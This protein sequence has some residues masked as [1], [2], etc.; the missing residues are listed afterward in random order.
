MVLCQHLNPRITRPPLDVLMHRIDATLSQFRMDDPT[1]INI[2]EG[3]SSILVYVSTLCVF[4]AG[5][6]RTLGFGVLSMVTV[7]EARAYL[8][9]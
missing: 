1:Q 5:N 2:V 8:A 9:W 4:F 7:T 3:C 6:G